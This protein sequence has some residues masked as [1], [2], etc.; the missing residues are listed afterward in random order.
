MESSVGTTTPRKVGS[1]RGAAAVARPRSRPRS[2]S[3]EPPHRRYV[4]SALRSELA[5]A[6][7]GPGP[8]RS[9]NAPGPGPGP[10][11]PR[12]PTRARPAVPRPQPRPSH[13]TTPITPRVGHASGPTPAG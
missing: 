3:P 8:R 9:R 10:R 13:L 1:L 5:M 6:W 7:H 11:R 4:S 2:S 12:P